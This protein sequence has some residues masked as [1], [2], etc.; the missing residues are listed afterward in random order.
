M[1]DDLDHTTALRQNR[2][3][4]KVHNLSTHKCGGGVAACGR[5]TGLLDELGDERAHAEAEK[6]RAEAKEYE[7]EAAGML[8]ASAYYQAAGVMARAAQLIDPYVMRDGQLV[9]KSDGKPV[10]P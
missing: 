10:T 6:L 2:L 1:S 3:H 8:N 4:N 5:L 7:K 9:R